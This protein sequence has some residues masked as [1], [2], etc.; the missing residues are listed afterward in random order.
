MAMPADRQRSHA[1]AWI[2]LAAILA[3]GLFAFMSLL[4]TR[5]DTGESYPDYSSLRADPMG[6]RALFESL[7]R[8][9]GVEAVRNFEHLDKL[10]G[11][12][13][14]TLLLCGMNSRSFASR[15]AVDG[16]A[17]ARFAASGGRLV[18][19]LNPST[20]MGRITRAYKGA[21]DEVDEEDEKQAAKSKPQKSGPD[22]TLKPSPPL[23][24]GPDGKAEKPEPAAGAH[25]HG[26]DAEASLAALL[27]ISAKSREFIFMGREGSPIELDSST[28]LAAADAPPWFS[29]VCLDDNPAQDWEAGWDVLSSPA[30]K[31]AGVKEGDASGKPKVKTAAEPS[32]W[33]VAATKG[34]ENIIMERTLGGGSVVVCTDRYFL[35][36]EALWKG[37]STAFLSWLLGDASRVIFEETHLG[38]GVGDEEGIMTLARRYRMHGLFLGGILLF[39]LYIWRNAF[40]LIPHAPEDDLGHW[41]ADAV[42]GQ[43]TASG[44]EGL[45]RRGITPP[46]L[47]SK[48]LD[49]WEETR[50]ASA[51]IPPERRAR[52]RALVAAFKN[53]R[54]APQAY[55]QIRDALHP[56]R[57]A[58]AP[59]PPPSKLP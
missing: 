49:I 39:A 8:L 17:L 30:N 57:S 23:S 22:K 42:A 25:A 48:C 18:I 55:S 12:Q 26:A 50:A 19:A 41:R 28:P 51:T 32:P 56:A 15:A 38:P 21:Q 14:Q 58:P 9:P 36:N 24:K 54:Q 35:S 46:R 45:L 7:G 52:A 16:K 43:S 1:G 29:N 33:H 13:H 20:S 31:T 59:L 27:K 2:A 11:A 40:S 37:P 5:Y 3:G 4:R 53:Q 34:G 10:Q 47:F 44:L 6:T